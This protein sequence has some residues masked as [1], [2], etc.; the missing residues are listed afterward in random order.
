MVGKV[1]RLI[2]DSY[3]HDFMDNEVVSPEYREKAEMFW[4]I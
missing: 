3:V 1:W 4:I 2:G